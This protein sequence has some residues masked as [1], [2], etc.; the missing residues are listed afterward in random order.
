MAS[1]SPDYANYQSPLS[2]RYGSAEMRRIF[3]DEHKWQSYRR[4]WVALAEAQHEAGLV[5]QEELD[6]LKAH[7]NNLDIDRIYQIEREETD[8]VEVAAIR[9]YAEKAK[10]G[11]G[12][13]HLGATSMDLSDNV[14]ALRHKE[15]LELVE[16]RLKATLKALAGQITNHADHACMGYTHLQPAEPTTV[17]YRLAFYANDLLADLEAL[18]FVME[19]VA[20][21]GMKGAVGTR[22]SYAAI[23]KG[24]G[25]SAEQ[26]DNQVMAALG[27]KSADITTQVVSRKFEYQI[28]STLAAIGSS[29]AKF[30]ADVR[31][32]QSPAFGEWSEPFRDKQV[33]SSAMPFKK[34]PIKTE[35]ICSLAR[36]LQVLP[37]VALENASL[38]YL[39]RTL[40]DSANRRLVLPEAFL[41]VDD[42]LLTAEKV[43]NGLIFNNQKIERNLANY[44]P[45]S[46]TESIIIEAVKNGADRQEMHERLREIAMEAWKEPNAGETMATLLYDDAAVRQFVSSQKLDELLDVSHHLGDARQR[47]R[48]LA[49]KIQAELGEAGGK[50]IG[51]IGG[52]QLGRMLAME[53]K[54][55]GYSVTVTDPTPQ[56][57]AG[58]VADQQ[59]VADYADEKAIRKLA[60]QIDFL[61]FEIELANA[62]ILNELLAKGIKISPSPKTLN[63]IK[64]KLAQK[65]FLAAHSIPVADFM[66]VNLRA[67]IEDAAGKWGYPLVLKARF[68]AYDG[69][70][71]AVI[72]S[73]DD[74]D[75]AMEKL[76]GRKLYVER[77]V[78][79]SKE[80]A[81]VIAR[82]ADGTTAAYPVVETIHKNNICHTVL[83]PARI[84][85]FTADAARNL[86]EQVMR[87]LEGAGVFAIEMFF[88]EDDRVLVNEIAPR[89]HNSGHLTIE[90]CVTS[91]FEQHVRA[92]TGLPLG[93]PDMKV[94]AAV[95]VNILGERSGPAQVTGL[96]ESLKIPGVSVHIYGKKET[97]PERKMGHITAVASTLDAALENATAA[98]KVINI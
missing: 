25:V 51:I 79:F 55:L 56:S 60:G 37:Q 6:D 17:G 86:A 82:Q 63:T 98:R 95:M 42:I 39:E 70:G 8:H 53:A 23:L 14:D 59:I 16:N 65:Q 87:H 58:Q 84:G 4:L 30:A 76:A 29:L 40:D 78:P 3:S 71:N 28:L 33:G 15:A 22:A 77:W 64:D 41:L 21:K 48:A 43:I 38:S 57:P 81:V 92:V 36:Y 18:R 73:A 91:Q 10:L 69:R 26:L 54:S 85:Q 46:A 97:R 67:D 96:E 94:P 20:G 52:G 72:E 32:L 49:E 89:V 93:R 62:D 44:A 35:K 12:K 88:A 24:T 11:G 61:T 68:D 80:L 50:R 31:I 27:I 5:S 45:F 74:I 83:A 66:P 90:A 2:F 13:V 19:H 7:Q 75:A 1:M 34:N 47:A 9:E